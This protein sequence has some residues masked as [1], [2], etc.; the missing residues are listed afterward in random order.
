MIIIKLEF[1]G[2]EN[3]ENVRRGG[4]TSVRSTAIRTSSKVWREFE[5]AGGGGSDNLKTFP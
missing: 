2:D 5:A 1:C 4:R 3:E